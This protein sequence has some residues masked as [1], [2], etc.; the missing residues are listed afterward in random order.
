MLEFLYTTLVLLVFCF[1]VFIIFPAFKYAKMVMIVMQ[2]I[3][4]FILVSKNFYENHDLYDSPRVQYIQSTNFY[5]IN[6]LYKTYDINEDISYNTMND[7][8]FSL[9][10][11]EKYPAQCLEHYFIAK[12][13]TCPITEIKFENKQSN[14]YQNYIDMS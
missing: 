9:I 1:L 7:N 5:P 14:I 4:S 10:Q 3:F 13:E 8:K 11:S 2:F 6:S 12:D